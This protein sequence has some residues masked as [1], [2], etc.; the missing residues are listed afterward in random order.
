MKILEWNEDDFVSTQKTTL[1]QSLLNQTLDRGNKCDKSVAELR[2]N[3][4]S[5]D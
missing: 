4:K 3:F 2:H 5:F 1:F